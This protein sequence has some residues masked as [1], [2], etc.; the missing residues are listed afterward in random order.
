MDT[1]KGLTPFKMLDT[2]GLPLGIC[3]DWMRSHGMTIISHEFIIEAVRAGWKFEKA[4]AVLR[5]AIAERE[6]TKDAD[7]VVKWLE[8]YCKS[9]IAKGAL[10]ESEEEN[11]TNESDVTRAEDEGMLGGEA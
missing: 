5:E 4:M 1:T 6:G 11:G 2:Y 3:I 8:P 7:A 9:L 10:K